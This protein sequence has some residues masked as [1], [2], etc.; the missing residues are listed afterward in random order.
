MK[1]KIISSIIASALCLSI[2]SGCGSSEAK[3]ADSS[4]KGAVLAVQDLPDCTTVSKQEGYFQEYMGD[5]ID[6][7]KFSAGRDILTAMTSGSVDF[8]QIGIC[9][10]T[11]GLTT[12]I[13]YKIIYAES[14]KRGS[15]GLVVKADSGIESVTDLKGKK[16]GV[17]FASDGHYGLLSA[18]EAAGLTAND[19]EMVNM[20][21]SELSAAWERGD[22]EAAY[23]W[24]PTLGNLK[25]SN[26]K[27]ILTIGDLLDSG[28]QTINFHIVRTAFAEEHP[29]Q[30]VAYIKALKK[31]VD[32]YE[33]DEAAAKQSI[34]TCLEKSVDEVDALMSDLYP[35]LDDQFTDAVFGNDNAANALLKVSTFLKGQDLIQDAKDLEFFKNA[36]DT[37][38]AE[39]AQ[40]E[41]SAESK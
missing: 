1:K 8:G 9:P 34:A 23:T 24:E 37:S 28:Y 21:T 17:T 35:N 5:N 31:G 26:G 13:D 38:Y 40:E 3:T 12:G 2:L 32:F 36:I 27:V 39:K 29:E 16:V 33:S 14:L 22:I 25:N 4:S 15:D 7:Q 11:T 30:V 6:I 20:S 10:T 41:L 18:L 19:V